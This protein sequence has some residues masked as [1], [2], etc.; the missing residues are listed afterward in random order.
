MRKVIGCLLTT[1]VVSGFVF[2]AADATAIEEFNKAEKY[3]S[4]K[5]YVCA[6]ELYEKSAI[7]GY[8]EAQYKLALMYGN[9]EGVPENS[10]QYIKWMKMASDK[11]HTQ[12]QYSMGYAYLYGSNVPKNQS[13][14]LR[15]LRLAAAKG[16]Q[17]AIMELQIHQM[18]NMVCLF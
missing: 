6:M 17:L 10:G 14:G 18:N 1:A 5:S 16:D 13:E 9:G 12:A 2:A 8:V 4:E 7:K 3:R 11:G 15:L